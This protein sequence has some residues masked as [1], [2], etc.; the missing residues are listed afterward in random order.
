MSSPGSIHGTAILFPACPPLTLQNEN[1]V[2]DLARPATRFWLRAFRSH[3]RAGMVGVA[4]P[5]MVV[6]WDLASVTNST[7]KRSP[8]IRPVSSSAAGQCGAQMHK[9]RHHDASHDWARDA[10][11]SVA[12]ALDSPIPVAD[13]AA[14]RGNVEPMVIAGSIRRI[15]CTQIE[16]SAYDPR[17][18]E[19]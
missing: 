2:S 9:R 7:R 11:T 19:P 10:F 14:N 18:C 3:R 17:A 1:E 13:E 5:R 12:G 4:R 16:L 6:E 15:C 8:S